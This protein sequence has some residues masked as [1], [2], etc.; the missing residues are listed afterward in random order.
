MNLQP[1]NYMS[2]KEEI[3][4]LRKEISRI[5]IEVKEVKDTHSDFEITD[6]SKFDKEEVKANLTLAYRHLENARMRLGKAIQASE[7]GESIYDKK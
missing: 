3:N 4:A 2:I 7:G 5:G 6:N 1:C